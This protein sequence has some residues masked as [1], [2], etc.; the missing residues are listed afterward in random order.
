[1]PGTKTAATEQMPTEIDIIRQRLADLNNRLVSN[2]VFLEQ[3][4]HK[5]KDTN[6]PDKK[7]SGEERAKDGVLSEIDCQLDYYTSHNARIETL[8]EKLS[9]LL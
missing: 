3:I 2:I 5:V 4:G 7:E 1:M 9:R 6:S 8:I